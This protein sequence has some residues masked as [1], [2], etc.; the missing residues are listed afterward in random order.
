MICRGFRAI[1]PSVVFLQ[2][3][4]WMPEG[5]MCSPHPHLA[6][7][8]HGQLPVA[9]GGEVLVLG[10]DGPFRFERSILA[11][12]QEDANSAFSGLS[13][14]NRLTPMMLNPMTCP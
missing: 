10:T 2:P 8:Q 1:Y 5:L 4:S 6:V 7:H 14:L 3:H 12:T 9:E 11:S 13:L